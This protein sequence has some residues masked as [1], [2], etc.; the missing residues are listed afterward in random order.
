MAWDFDT[1]NDVV[2]DV[3][4]ETVTYTPSSGSPYSVSGVVARRHIEVLGANGASSVSYAT[5]VGI[6]ISA[7]AAKPSKADRI[8][9]SG[10]QY[11]IQDVQE[12]SGGWALFVLHKS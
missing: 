9:I 8:T 4:G 5:T 1:L 12:D 6:K 3:F 2:G 7:L 11:R 10:A